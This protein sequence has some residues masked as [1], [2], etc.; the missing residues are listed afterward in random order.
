ME[1]LGYKQKNKMVYQM[2]EN[3]KV[4]GASEHSGH[5]V[6]FLGITALRFQQPPLR[7]IFTIDLPYS[8]RFPVRQSLDAVCAPLQQKSID[9]DQF[10]DM[11]TAR[12]VR[13]RCT[14]SK[15]NAQRI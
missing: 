2:I 12:I 1:S 6:G 8:L 9:F 10:L 15:R 11:M 7:H 4:S 14:Q 3:M 5:S 13:S